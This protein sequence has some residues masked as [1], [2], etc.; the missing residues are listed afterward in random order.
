MSRGGEVLVKRIGLMLI[1]LLLALAPAG[2]A[3]A[4]FQTSDLN[5]KWEVFILGYYEVF[6]T[7]AFGSLTVDT[8]QIVDGSGQYHSSPASFG[9]A[10]NLNQ[11][12]S[13]NARIEGYYGG[14]SFGYDLL[15]GRMNPRKDTIVGS[16]RNDSWWMC[17]FYL[18]KAD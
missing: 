7:Y 12:G 10:I 18:I 17:T 15:T 5:G 3:R 16:G 11:D 6:T 14:G 1:A 8:A 13:V 9:G 4:Q 2:V